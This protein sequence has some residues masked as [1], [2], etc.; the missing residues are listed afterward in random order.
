MTGRLHTLA[1]G[2]KVHVGGRRRPI[3]TR[4]SHPHLFLPLH[5][6]AAKAALPAV[7]DY[8]YTT[9]NTAALAD[10]LGNDVLGDCTSA[11]AGHII[12][13]MTGVAG[14]PVA[15][16]RDQA[17]AFYSKST[18]YD[19]SNP[20][21]DQGG[22]E[23]TVCTTWQQQGY[24]ADG[25]HKIV[26]WA[27]IEDFDPAFVKW[28]GF[29]F[30]LY[31]GIELS[32]SWMDAPVWD[33]GQPADPNDGHC[34]VSCAGNAQ[35]LPI[36]TWGQK[37]LITYAAIAER[38]ADSAGGNL[39]AILTQDG[40]NAATKLTPGGVDWPTLAADLASMGAPPSPISYPSVGP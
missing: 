9:N 35:G 18:G 13:A 32:D 28:A 37:R 39:F 25:S 3:V 6:Y 31:F 14:A 10:I 7:P 21:S 15:I 12:D 23:V 34:V 33:V 16:T 17:I 5:R 11:G 36:I 2:Q 30:P 27:T 22:D 8:D 29:F 19:P 40:L 38:C 24:L 1:S 20:S 26:G 4:A